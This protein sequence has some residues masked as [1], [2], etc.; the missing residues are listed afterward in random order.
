[1]GQSPEIHIRGI[2]GSVNAE[3]KP[4]ILLDNVPIPDM[5][6]VNPQDIETV[7][8]LKDAASA[9]IYG[10]RGAW[11]VI[12]L[13]SKKGKKASMRVSYNNSIRMVFTNEHS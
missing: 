9:S 7:S 13:T 3:A 8:I 11:G 6:M 10:A 1:L 5:M 4:L 2:E 12:L